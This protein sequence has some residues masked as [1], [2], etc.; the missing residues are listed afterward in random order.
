MELLDHREAQL[1][2]LLLPLH[3]NEFQLFILVD[4][5]IDAVCNFGSYI[6]TSRKS[7]TP[8]LPPDYTQEFTESIHRTVG[9]LFLEQEMF[10]TSI[11]EQGR[12]CRS[13]KNAHTNKFVFKIHHC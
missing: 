4:S 12:Q 5:G 2:H 9:D 11:W 8:K 3:D 6:N 7:S 1:Y 10:T 13:I